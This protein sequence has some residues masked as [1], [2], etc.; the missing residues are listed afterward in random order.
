MLLLRFDDVATNPVTT[1]CIGFDNGRFHRSRGLL[2]AAFFSAVVMIAI[3]GCWVY[4]LGPL[5]R[6]LLSE[7]ALILSV[8]LG[9]AVVSW[10]SGAIV[11]WRSGRRA[12]RDARLRD[13]FMAGDA[14]SFLE[15]WSVGT[16]VVAAVPVVVWLQTTALGL[17]FGPQLETVSFVTA[18]IILLIVGLL[19][20]GP[21]LDHAVVMGLRE[22]LEP[23]GISVKAIGRF[24]KEAAIASFWI[25]AGLGVFGVA[26]LTLRAQRMRHAMRP[27]L[28]ELFAEA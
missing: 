23:G 21:V 12:R 17:A 24:I 15:S 27:H 6:R 1:F 16:A 2:P 22:S 25:I 26:V 9:T 7:G 18:Y 3:L 10:L 11:G 14:E 8:S 28:A 20:L 13:L 4:Y 5:G 19:A